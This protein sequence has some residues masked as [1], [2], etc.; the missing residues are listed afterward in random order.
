MVTMTATEVARNFSAV[1]DAVAGGETILITRGG[2][3]VA[4]LTATPAANGGVVREVLRRHAPDPGWA[5]DIESVR[6]L[7]YVED[8]G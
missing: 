5:D 8:R 6:D 4:E 2:R 7:L 1:L 3:R